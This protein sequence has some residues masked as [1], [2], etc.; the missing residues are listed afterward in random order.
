MENYYDFFN[1]KNK[2]IIHK[3]ILLIERNGKFEIT[4]RF[5]QDITRM[6][7]LFDFGRG[8]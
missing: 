5:L 4:K 3:R 8:R 7:Q 6:R 2:N 1:N